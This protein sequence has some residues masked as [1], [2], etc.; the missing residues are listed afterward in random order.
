MYFFDTTPLGRILNRFSKDMD[1]LGNYFEVRTYIQIYKYLY[2]IFLDILDVTIP[3]NLRMLCN[4]LYNV[5]GTLF[6]ICFANYWFIIVVIPI[7]IM[8]YFLQKFYV[9]TARQ[10]NSDFFFRLNKI[11][12]LLILLN[13]KIIRSS[14]W[15]R[16]PDR[17]STVISA[18]PSMVH[19]PS[20]PT[21]SL[22]GT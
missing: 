13:K 20:E 21:A 14:V 18:R 9:T 6:V 11:S 8:Y 17:R 16:L 15:S 7:L 12:Y 5:I 19:P 10:V 1:I 2:I 4:Q 22:I 3:M